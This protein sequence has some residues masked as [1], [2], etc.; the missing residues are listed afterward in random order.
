MKHL[1]LV[2][3]LIISLQG[4]NSQRSKEIDSR[5]LKINK[6]IEF[7]Y[8]SNN[9]RLNHLKSRLT[10]VALDKVKQL[11]NS[12]RKEKTENEVL[13]L[14]YSS[15][16]NSE[17]ETLLQNIN[18]NSNQDNSILFPKKEKKKQT[19][20]NSLE[21]KRNILYDKLYKKDE[22]RYNLFKNEFFRLEAINYKN[23]LILK[24]LDSLKAKN[25]RAYCKNG[26]YEVITKDRNQNYNNEN[27]ELK[28]EIALDL[29]HIKSI[30]KKTTNY[31]DFNYIIEIIFDTIGTQKIYELTKNTDYNQQLAIVVFGEIITAPFINTTIENGKVELSG[32][33]NIFEVNQIISS[34]KSGIIK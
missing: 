28:R 30:C 24:K 25:K 5:I 27:I 2:F 1:S 10:F 26:I 33:N 3:I 20:P 15:L 34:I 9:I 16:T 6:F 23:A 13:D 14:F 12:I 31:S 29:K 8:K 18:K 11:E 19:I 21:R 17:I 22:E 7:N 32:N 4:C